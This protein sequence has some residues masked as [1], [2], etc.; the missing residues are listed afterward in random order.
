MTLVEHPKLRR[1]T[2]EDI[3]TLTAVWRRSVE[4]SHHFLTPA[5]IDMLEK[6]VDDALAG[7]TVWVAEAEGRVVGFMAMNEDMIEALF[8]D[9]GSMGMGLGTR[10]IT[11]ARE[12]AGLDRPL[13]VDV[14]E[15]NPDGIAFYLARGFVQTG[16]SETDGMGRPW[17]LLHLQI[18]T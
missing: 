17:P 6:E 9:P 5:D 18:A 4:A 16:R 2:L 14:N 11:L 7:L 12:M 15:Q 8:I 10:F 13:R 3:P 1:G